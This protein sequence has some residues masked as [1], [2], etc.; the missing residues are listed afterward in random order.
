MSPRLK[1][2]KSKLKQQERKE[3]LKMMKLKKTNKAKNWF[4]MKSV[5]L[6]NL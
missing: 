6:I 5:R 4:E 3:E 1:V 2:T